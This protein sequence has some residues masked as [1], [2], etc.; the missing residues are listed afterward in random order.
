MHAT[1]IYK[2]ELED[3]KFYFGCTSGRN[4]DIGVHFMGTGC[5]WTRRYRPLRYELAPGNMH[6]LVHYVLQYMDLFGHNNVRGGYWEQ[7]E[8]MKNPPP[9]LGKFR[10]GKTAYNKCDKCNVYGH[11]LQRCHIKKDAD[12]DIHMA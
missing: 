1:Y 3:G 4:E 5:E 9:V 11:S 10:K 7:A 2:L 6:D 12:G 8:L